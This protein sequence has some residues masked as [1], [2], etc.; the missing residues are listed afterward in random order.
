MQKEVAARGRCEAGNKE[1]SRR[2]SP[3]F[4]VGGRARAYFDACLDP[5]IPVGGSGHAGRLSNVAN[6]KR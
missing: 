4:H 1:C 3:A 2:R 5:Q 6:M